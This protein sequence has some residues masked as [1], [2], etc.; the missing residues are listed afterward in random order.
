MTTNQSI[1]SVNHNM[2]RR[3]FIK[4]TSLALGSAMLTACSQPNSQ[5]NAKKS[6]LD[7]VILT[8]DW[9]AEADYGGFYQAVATGIYKNHGLD[10]TIIQGGPRLNNNMLLMGNNTDVILGTA[11]DAIKAIENNIPKI[12]VA[13]I[14]QKYS[15]IL[16]AHPNQGNDTLEKFKGKPILVSSSAD[17]TYWPV[18][19]K[20][21]G[22]TDDQKRPYNSNLAPFLADKQAVQQGVVNSEPFAIEKEA[23]FKPV[24]ILLSDYGYNPY[25]YVIQTTKKLVETNPD[26]VQRFVD[27]SIKGYYSYLENP[28]PGN[29]LIKKDNPEMTD[30]WL[31]FGVTQIKKYELITGGDAA[32]LGIG[33]MLDSRWQEFFNSMVEVKIFPPNINYKEAYTLQFV[34]KGVEYYKK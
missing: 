8:I 22:F 20:K 28:V 24:V 32:K 6:N 30:D 12:S 11:P 15:Q 7:S 31:N 34:N 10:V 29:E 3:E 25:S 5:N 2:K 27:A 16:I 21:Y 4:Y 9:I 13:A 14:Y 18:L 23:G 19:R 17:A 1:L 33:A 26:L